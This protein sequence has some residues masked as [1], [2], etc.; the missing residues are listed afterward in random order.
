MFGPG[1]FGKGFFGGG[2]FG[3]SGSTTAVPTQPVSIYKTRGRWK[4]PYISDPYKL[5]KTRFPS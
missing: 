4:G 3:P 2:F 5:K 1:F